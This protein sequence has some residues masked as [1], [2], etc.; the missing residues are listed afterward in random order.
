[1]AKNL[2]RT[3]PKCGDYLGVVVPEPKKPVKDVPIDVTCL[4]CSYELVR[5]VVL[6]RKSPHLAGGVID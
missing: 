5:K 6:G 3:C 4:G 2:A 1:M